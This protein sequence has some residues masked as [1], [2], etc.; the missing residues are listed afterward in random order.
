MTIRRIEGFEIDRNIFTFAGQAGV[1]EGVYRNV[2][3]AQ[4][5]PIWS[6][7]SPR[8]GGFFIRFANMLGPWS[9]T[10]EDGY[11]TDLNPTPVDQILMGF[12]VRWTP[13]ANKSFE[14]INF[15]DNATLGSDVEQFNL[16]FIADGTG[17]NYKLRFERGST[18]ISG[19]GGNCETAFEFKPGQWYYFEINAIVDGSAGQIQLKADGNE[20]FFVTNANTQDKGS[21]VWGHLVWT[22]DATTGNTFD[23]DDI[24]LFS[25][26]A[27]GNFNALVGD[28]IIE[29]LH[30]KDDSQVAANQWTPVGAA[31]R[32]ECVDEGRV[33][34][35]DADNTYVE[36]V[37]NAL[38]QMFVMDD[39][40][41]VNA[42]D[43]NAITWDG[44][45]RLRA[46]GSR[47]V[48][49]R[50]WTGSGFEDKPNF[51]VTS[52]VYARKIFHQEVPTGPSFESDV[53]AA[54]VEYGFE[55][56]A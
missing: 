7:S 22:V 42:A 9:W 23:L 8:V 33:G 10:M 18:L 6:N 44:D 2:T 51:A 43:I 26:E 31:N 1:F 5:N 50:F 37:D 40:S 3:Q 21:G 20:K 47:N 45:F 16:K 24:Y 53:T 54:G 35:M 15:R 46:Q 48:R 4:K 30:P 55:S 41:F 17:A 49:Y 39:L 36:V 28:Q 11:P 25:K 34:N 56:R 27:S 38:T 32:Y 14:L 12:A 52:T 29:A 13:T 19:T